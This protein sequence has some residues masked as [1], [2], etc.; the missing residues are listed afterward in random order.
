MFGFDVLVDQ[1][2][3][4]HLLE[5]NFAPSLNTDSDLDLEVKSEVV[6]DLLSLAGI[7]GSPGL[8]QPAS[9][10]KSSPEAPEERHRRGQQETRPSDGRGDNT[11][12][13]NKGDG[14]QRR[15]DDGGGPA[16][17]EGDASIAPPP[18]RRC[19]TP[20]GDEALPRRPPP[21]KG[22]QQGRAGVDPGAVAAAR[23]GVG[24]DAPTAARPATKAGDRVR[25]SG[26]PSSRQTRD[27]GGGGGGGVVADRAAPAWE[28]SFRGGDG[29]ASPSAEEVR[30]SA[31]SS[32]VLSCLRR[33]NDLNHQT[34]L[35]TLC[36]AARHC[37]K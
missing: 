5:V 17:D 2:Q 25:P 21:E 27:R 8:H 16:T 15:D 6:A 29:V 23:G 20:S 4:P 10:A 22:E 12:G 13:R 9:V 24:F 32:P 36:E 14:D 35:Y 26:R 7:R 33:E 18:T 1:Q 3:R 28:G 31:L 34:S 11:G 37:A 30:S 19:R